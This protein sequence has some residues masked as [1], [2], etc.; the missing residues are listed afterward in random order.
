MH[1]ALQ[2]VIGVSVAVLCIAAV[3]LLVAAYRAA[4]RAE[5]VLAL[6][7]RDLAPL[8]VEARGLTADLRRLTHQVQDELGR[9]SSLTLRAE[10]VADGI[11]RIVSGVAGFTRAG[12]LV[13]IAAGLR[14]GFDAFVHRLRKRKGGHDG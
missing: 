12:Q 8:A 6:V 5:R 13:G 3:L 9:L 11:G 14:T 4:V 1:W 2:L 10:E 7:E